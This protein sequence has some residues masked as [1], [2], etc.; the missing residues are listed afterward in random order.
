M[1]IIE[2]MVTLQNKTDMKLKNDQCHKI[3]YSN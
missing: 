3:P 2:A 1:T